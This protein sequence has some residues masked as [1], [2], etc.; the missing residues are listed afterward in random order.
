MVIL[1]EIVIQTLPMEVFCEHRTDHG[2]NGNGWS[3]EGIVDAAF[4]PIVAV[5]SDEGNQKI[6]HLIQDGIDV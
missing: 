2:F 4:H 1:P 3:A 5:A 6:G